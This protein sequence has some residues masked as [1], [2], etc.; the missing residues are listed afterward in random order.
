MDYPRIFFYT[1]NTNKIID[2][3]K[4]DK[5]FKKTNEF[6]NNIN[7][8]K[9]IYDDSINEVVAETIELYK[10][11]FNLGYNQYKKELEV[12]EEAEELPKSVNPI[13]GVKPKMFNQNDINMMKSFKELG[14]S[15]CEI[16]KKYKCNEK[17]IRNYLKEYKK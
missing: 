15:N 13:A 3:E 12:T 14:Y 4:T 2:Q 9:F 5:F 6:F 8:D 11:A 16:A 1:D 7:N 17:T 10:Y